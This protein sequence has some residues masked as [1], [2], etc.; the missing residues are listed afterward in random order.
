[1]DIQ[2]LK[3]DHETGLGLAEVEIDMLFARITELEKSLFDLLNDCINF[4]DG[5]YTETIIKEASALLQ[6]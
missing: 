6:K 5:N 3:K 4:N 2:E 1:M